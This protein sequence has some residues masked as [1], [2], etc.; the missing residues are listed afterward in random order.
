MLIAG[1]ALKQTLIE[2]QKEMQVGDSLILPLLLKQA[3]QRRSQRR[4]K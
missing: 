1:S 4:P 3:T 2:N